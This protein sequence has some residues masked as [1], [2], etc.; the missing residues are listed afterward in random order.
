MSVYQLRAVDECNEHVRPHY[1]HSMEGEG[2]LECLASKQ[3]EET[4]SPGDS[5]I[6]K[7]CGIPTGEYKR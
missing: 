1:V 6:L 3:M 2:M 5:L 7:K 4:R